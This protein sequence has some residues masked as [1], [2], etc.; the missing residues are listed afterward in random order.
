MTVT[1][2]LDLTGIS[3]DNL[4]ENEQHTLTEVNNQTY[5]TIVPEFAPFYL[6]NFTLRHLDD[7]GNI[8]NLVEGVDFYL[9]LPYIGASRSIGKMLYGG[10]TMNTDFVN[11]LIMANYQTLGGTW[12]AD[13][14]YV[15]N[16]LAEHIYNPRIVVWDQVTNIQET[17]PPT[18]H[19]QSLD[20]IYGYQELINAINAMAASI[21]NGPNLDLPVLQ[22]LIQRPFPSRAEARFCTRN[23]RRLS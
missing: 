17:F 13:A 6:D 3:P 5:R 1:Y 9:S 20:Y 8:T 2:N 16:M 4:I 7:E 18:N 21:A 14:G 23:K 15:L 22:Y 12:N 19:D 10:I 11:G